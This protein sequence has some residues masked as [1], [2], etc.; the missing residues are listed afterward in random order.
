MSS[1][2]IQSVDLSSITHPT[3]VIDTQRVKSQV[4]QYCQNKPEHHKTLF[5]VKSNHTSTVLNSIATTV[6]GFDISNYNE[7]CCLGDVSDKIISVCGPAF[8]KEDFVKIQQSNIKRL[9]V[10]FDSLDQFHACEP[11]IEPST[12]IMFRI[13][14]TDLDSS[15]N[16]AFGINFDEVV[17]HPNL[18]GL[19]IHM[20]RS[21]NMRTIENYMEFYRRAREIPNVRS[22]NFGGGQHHYN[23]F[24]LRDLLNDPDV[25][26]FIE[27]GQPFFLDAIYAIGKVLSVKQQRD[28][29][30]VITSLSIDCHLKWSRD[31]RLLIDPSDTVNTLCGPTCQGTDRIGEYHGD[32]AVG[33]T[34]IFENINPLSLEI[35]KSFNGIDQGKILYV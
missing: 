31:K 28:V 25:E 7:L 27:P 18:V 15:Y 2:F 12:E 11:Y 19:H 8:D 13:C 9:I 1:A 26:C 14:T 34:V 16:S 17:Q 4:E 21:S 33:D 20:S 10:V 22:L 24:E 29:R 23:W 30:N 3:F 35:A 6:D 5:S 32:F